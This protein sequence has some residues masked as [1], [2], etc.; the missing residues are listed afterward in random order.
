[1]IPRRKIDGIWGFGVWGDG[2]WI[3]NNRDPVSQVMTLIPNRQQGPVPPE[4][5]NRSPSHEPHEICLRNPPP[6]LFYG[7]L[8]AK[9][10]M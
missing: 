8:T 4:L 3:V 10:I 6:S 9:L 7:D 2:I 1:M 5:E